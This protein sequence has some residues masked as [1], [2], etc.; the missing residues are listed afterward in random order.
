MRVPIQEHNVAEAKI[1]YFVSNS[2]KEV[3]CTRFR[4]N[5][6]YDVAR[7]AENL[8]FINIMT[9]DLRGP[10]DGKAD[11][12][13]PINSRHFDTWA[14]K[15]L[16]TKD[17]INYW[18]MKGAPKEKL[19]IGIP[20]YGR[21]FTLASAENNVPRSTVST[22]LQ[23]SHLVLLSSHRIFSLCHTISQFSSPP[24]IDF[25]HCATPLAEYKVVCCN[26]Q[27]RGLFK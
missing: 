1:I 13:S 14:F 27:T 4:V 16:N 7:L 23:F 25:F 24:F 2:L 9:Y 5:E 22:L 3:T 19:V 21:S 8:D 17:G 11:H 18:A 12:H 26:L 20:F 6:G 10:W 15:T